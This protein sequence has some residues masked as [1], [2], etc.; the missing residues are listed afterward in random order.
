MKKKAF[1]QGRRRQPFYF[2]KRNGNEQSQV[3]QQT[4]LLLTPARTTAITTAATTASITG[5]RSLV[6]GVHL[7]RA[8]VL[9]GRVRCVVWVLHVGTLIV[10]VVHVAVA[11]FVVV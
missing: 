6:V 1:T 11:F 10:G 5:F 2:V 9:R 7:I 8:I 3:L 4:S